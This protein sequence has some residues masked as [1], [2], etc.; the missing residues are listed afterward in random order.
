M[1]KFDEKHWSWIVPLILMIATIVAVATGCGPFGDDAQAAQP[2]P[3]P[4]PND[5]VGRAIG[6]N[7]AGIIGA[8]IFVAVMFVLALRSMKKNS[9]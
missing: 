6:I 4:A 1:K 7:V 5:G 3:S 8:A 2:T 9:D